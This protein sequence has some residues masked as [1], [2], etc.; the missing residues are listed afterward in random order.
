MPVDVHIAHIPTASQLVPWV[1]GTFQLAVLYVLLWLLWGDAF[2]PRGAGFSL[3][4]L[5]LAST[6]CG[7][8]VKRLSR[9][10]RIMPGVRSPTDAYP[11]LFPGVRARPRPGG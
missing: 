8:L 1:Y 2:L 3:L 9:R 6:A 11:A 5:Y 7:L 10:T 4:V